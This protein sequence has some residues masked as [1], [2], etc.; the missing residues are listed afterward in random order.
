MGGEGSP[1]ALT[2]VFAKARWRAT[3]RHLGVP[4]AT[5]P[6]VHAPIHRPRAPAAAVLGA[7]ILASCASVP[8]VSATPA[9]NASATLVSS[10]APTASPPLPT[11]AAPLSDRYGVLVDVKSGY[12]RSETDPRTLATLSAGD[13]PAF[14]GAVS[15]DGRALA[16]WE[17][18]P[19]AGAR[20]LWLLERIPGRPRALLTLPETEVAATSTGGGVAWSSDGT[21]LL[22]AVNS[23]DYV[24]SP[25]VDA[26][27]LY[28]TL[29]QVDVSTGSVREIA[30]KEPGHPFFPIAWDRPRGIS[31]AVQWGP[32]GFT[33]GYFTV[34]DGAAP[35]GAALPATSLPIALQAARDA[36]RVLMRTFFADGPRA[37]YVW[38]LADP[39]QRMALEPVGNERVVAAMWRNEREIVVSLSATA[40]ARDADR[41]EVWPLEGPRRVVLRGQHRLDAVRPDGTAAITSV[42]VVDLTTGATARIAAMSGR[43]VASLLL[44]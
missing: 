17:T 8:N 9:V 7:A 30:R 39:A 23:R 43:V 28:T 44:R 11:A 36:S 33:M 3:D 22:I 42:G 27:P 40:D 21:G 19:T 37:V 35:V 32:G 4:S 24:P 25:V 1:R 38:P 29:R 31:A 34:R 5:V 15:P 18:S 20:V 2:A 13:D 16:Y 6:H 10:P 41:L 12:V 26:P 14:H